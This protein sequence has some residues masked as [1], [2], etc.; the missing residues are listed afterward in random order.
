LRPF[1]P[2]VIFTVSASLFTPRN[3]AARDRSPVVI[4]FAIIFFSLLSA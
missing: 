3:I 1:G 4:C 2:S